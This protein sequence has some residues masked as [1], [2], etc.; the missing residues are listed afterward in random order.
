MFKFKYFIFSFILFSYTLCDLE[1][2]GITYVGDRYCPEVSMDDPLSMQS[3]EELAHVDEVIFESP[4]YLV[5]LQRPRSMQ[6]TTY[7]R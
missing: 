1:F 6:N 3:L 4:Y 5:T 2:K 7:D